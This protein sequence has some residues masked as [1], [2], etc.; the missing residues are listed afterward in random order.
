MSKTFEEILTNML[1]QMEVEIT[2]PDIKHI[3]VAVDALMN[4]LIDE[5][6]DELDKASLSEYN[7]TENML[8]K[9]YVTA[10]RAEL[11]GNKT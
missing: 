1:N 7:S 2:S 9:V 8:G 4:L 5:R 11:E 3:N 10:R 6:I